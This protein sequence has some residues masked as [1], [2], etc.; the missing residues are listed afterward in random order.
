MDVTLRVK[1]S[2]D[3]ARRSSPLVEESVA[4]AAS[5]P[6]SPTHYSSHQLDA[7]TRD[8]QVSLDDYPA[9]TPDGFYVAPRPIAL[10][11][12]VE[13]FGPANAVI[14]RES[15]MFAFWQSRMA[16]RTEEA[17]AAFI[18]CRAWLRLNAVKQKSLNKELDSEKLRNVAAQH[19]GMVSH[20]VLIA[21]LELEH[22]SVKQAIDSFG[23]PRANAWT[24]AHL[25]AAAY[26]L[27]GSR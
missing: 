15:E 27:G 2:R 22:F 13:W 3:N 14:S 7:A 11:R 8:M 1:P 26:K 5:N 19:I 17:L 4:H 10:P 16:M 24:N 25:L 20:G 18:A 23:Q 12:S 6:C 21:A 9:L